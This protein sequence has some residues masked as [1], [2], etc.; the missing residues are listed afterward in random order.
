MASEAQDPP[1]NEDLLANAVAFLI[2][3]GDYEAAQ[4]LLACE[5]VHLRG[6]A[7]YDTG[8]VIRMEATVIGPRAVYDA[9]EQLNAWDDW[10]NPPHGIGADMLRALNA[11]TG[12]EH[13]VDRLTAA[14]RGPGAFPDWRKELDEA[15]RQVVHN[16][17]TGEATRILHWNTMRYRSQ[18]EIRIAKALEAAGVMFFPNCRARLP[19]GGDKLGNREPDFLVFADGRCGILEVDGDPWHPPERA[20]QEHERDRLFRRQGLMVERY[21][22]DRCFESPDAVVA[23]FM[24]LLRKG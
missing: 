13:D 17:A 22:A 11:C 9:V 6:Y 15:A 1:A 24:T 12:R 21:S 14:V 10:N 4:V 19:I 7:E 20:A 5:A 2:D 23:E 3:G 18:S 8:R 16:Q